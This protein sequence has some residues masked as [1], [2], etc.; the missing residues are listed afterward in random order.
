MPVR[1]ER[2]SSAAGSQSS[3]RPSGREYPESGWCTGSGAASTN[4]LASSAEANG[5]AAT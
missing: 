5:P 4:L 2:P 3:G 1:D